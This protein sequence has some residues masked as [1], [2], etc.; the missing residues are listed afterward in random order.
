LSNTKNLENIISKIQEDAKTKASEIKAGA[1]S[2]AKAEAESRK[3]E[4]RKKA[5]EI[6]AL[7][8]ADAE[9][10]REQALVSVNLSVRNEKLAAKQEVIDRVF[11]KALEELNALDDAKLS[12]FIRAAVRAAKIKQGDQ[13]I[14][15]KTSAI[16]P[17]DVDAR[18]S[19]YK[20]NV[21]IDGGFVLVSGGVEQNN[22][23]KALIEFYRNELEQDVIHTLF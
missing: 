13:I 15:P 6:T 22:T 19:E 2:A 11:A 23:F 14:L 5:D 3:A 10:I 8:K 12:G 17:G 1:Q 20:G 21:L 16:K 18:L 7:A 4:A 9:K